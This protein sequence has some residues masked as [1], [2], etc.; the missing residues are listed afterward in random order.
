MKI[1]KTNMNRADFFNY[2]IPLYKSGNLKK[3]SDEVLIAIRNKF[4]TK[5]IECA[6]KESVFIEKNGGKF[7]GKKS[8][9][10]LCC[11]E[12]CVSVRGKYVLVTKTSVQNKVTQTVYEI[13]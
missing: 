7:Y 11:A 6:T 8:K 1:T 3:N 5:T 12:T 2:C 4:N 10:Y 13:K 9:T